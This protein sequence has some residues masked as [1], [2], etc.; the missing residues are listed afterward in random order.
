MKVKDLEQYKQIITEQ[1]T[2]EYELGSNDEP[3][4]S[5]LVGEGTPLSYYIGNISN[6]AEHSNT[7]LFYELLQNASDAQADTCYITFNDDYFLVINN[8]KPFIADGR[9]D[10]PGRLRSFLTK[11]KGVKSESSEAIGEHGQGSKL[12]Y[13]LLLP[14]HAEGVDFLK[15][16]DRLNIH[17][18]QKLDGLILFSWNHLPRLLELMDWEDDNLSSGDCLAEDIPL[19]TK[20]ILTYYPGR[21]GER[22]V[23]NGEERTLFSKEEAKAFTSFIKKSMS[24]PKVNA[25]SFDRGAAIFVKLG[26]GRASKLQQAI[27]QDLSAG[28]STSLVLLPHV[29]R[30]QINDLLV[31]QNTS[32]AKEELILDVTTETTGKQ[33]TAW[34]YYPKSPELVN[35]DLANFFKYFPI[36]KEAYGL[37]FIINSK[38]FEITTS[39][40]NFNFDDEGNQNILARI[41]EQLVSLIDDFGNQGNTEGLI[42]VISAVL[43]T[44]LD[45]MERNR[46]SGPFI[47]EIFFT[48]LLTA[49]RRN[50]P[51]NSGTKST[52]DDT[53]KVVLKKSN[54]PISSTDLNDSF[55]WI[56]DSLTDYADQLEEHL[57]IPSWGVADLHAHFINESSWKKWV[58]DL[59]AEDYQELLTELSSLSTGQLKQIPFLLFSNNEVFSLADL[60]AQENTVLLDERTRPLQQILEQHDILCGGSEVLSNDDLINKVRD[61]SPSNEQLLEQFVKLIDYSS[62]SRDEKWL[63]FRTLR[64]QWKLSK[65]DLRSKIEIFQ[66]NQGELRPLAYLLDKHRQK[67]SSG[68]LRPFQIHPVEVYHDEFNPYFLQK[69]EIW[70]VIRRHWREVSAT[71]SPDNYAQAIKELE[72][73]YENSKGS[74]L[75]DDHAW[76]MTNDM[77]LAPSSEVFFNRKIAELDAEAY[78]R[79]NKVVSRATNSKTIHALH[80]SSI[81]TQT[82]APIPSLG[83]GEFADRFEEDKIT[84]DQ[85]DLQVLLRSKELDE[86]FFSKLKIKAGPN[87]TYQL[88][89]ED[90][91]KQFFTDDPLVKSFLETQDKYYELPS[92]LS[93][94]FNDD[95][96]LIGDFGDKTEAFALQLIGDF[97]SNSA[98]IDLVQRC[99]QATK[100]RYLQGV[101]TLELSAG[102]E[103]QS[104]RGTYKGKLITL[105]VDLQQEAIIRKI[106]QIDG[107]PFSDFTHEEMITVTYGEQEAS[108]SF[109]LSSLIP[110]YQGLSD[111]WQAVK[112]KL[113]GVKTGNLFVLDRLPLSTIA[114]EIIDSAPL[115][116]PVQV[117]FF[118]AFQQSHSYDSKLHHSSAD[119]DWEGLEKERVLNK[120]Y[121]NR[122][123]GFGN[124]LPEQLLQP[125]TYIYAPNKNELLLPNEQLPDWVISWLGN[126]TKRLSY[127]QENGLHGSNDPVLLFRESILAREKIESEV[128]DTIASKSVWTNNTLQWCE[129]SL[130]EFYYKE[131]SYQALHQLIIRS[132][133]ENESL[134]YYLLAFDF[135]DANFEATQMRLIPKS[136]K[137]YYITEYL[138][139]ELSVWQRIPQQL[140]DHNFVDASYYKIN[141]DFRELLND[142]GWK[143]ASLQKKFSPLDESETQEWQARQYLEWKNFYNAKYRILITPQEI[144]FF[145]YFSVHD[146]NVEQEVGTFSKGEAVSHRTEDGDIDLILYYPGAGQASILESITAQKDV[147]FAGDYQALIK[148]LGLFSAELEE[149]EQAIL[150]LTKEKGLTSEDLLGINKDSLM[151]IRQLKLSP[152]ELIKRLESEEAGYELGRELNDEELNTLRVLIK[153]ADGDLLTA[154]ARNLDKIKQLLESDDEGSKP[155]LLIGLIG[156]ILV[157][158]WLKLEYGRENVQY[159]AL[160][161]EGD[162]WHPSYETHDLQ[163]NLNQQTYLL[164][165]KTTI[166]PIR[167]LDRTVAFFIKK[168]QYEYIANHPEQQYYIYR[169]SLQELGL[170]EFYRSLKFI[171]DQGRVDIINKFYPIIVKKI[172]SYLASPANRSDLKKLRMVFRVTIPEQTKGLF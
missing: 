6:F 107:K 131:S 99:S 78:S 133:Q 87:N 165:V 47:K 5:R 86:R 7:Q 14:A 10:Q 144:P 11:N 64:D 151:L 106:A 100:Q 69:E 102:N 48:N 90:K 119:L 135:K 104:Y 4:F 77:S 49:L 82:F 43:E 117:A 98:F 44:E 137:G 101:S 116:H 152:E 72:A 124:I 52:E 96:A 2:S 21:I 140:E 60:A 146:E 170:Y 46:Q 141:H 154:I 41:G 29:K 1:V 71:M 17:L 53:Y 109:Q 113:Q 16:A 67:A 38:E 93:E 145:Y 63:L 68:I 114:Q 81:G 123:T 169:I 121:K 30:I 129:D 91:G 24:H 34:F 127:L 73:L 155:S 9:T 136:E 36:T 143:K 103:I 28:L 158:E 27:A 149:G 51:T 74:P 37:K 83:L 126:N 13:D 61:H 85:V 79:L 45:Q 65:E 110:K 120:L 108:A 125:A 80:Y 115:T 54:L 25:S 159:T 171:K 33:K 162:R 35:P 163:L 153:K 40:Q 8:G 139:N 3:L 84:V 42:Q 57:N 134:P 105:A 130:G 26:N 138:P 160:K 58:N 161:K 112:D 19:L 70:K 172:H 122:I 157:H 56:D 167:D 23:V 128:I 118:V 32:F 12:L 15:K 150:D 39:R 168:K 166:K 31:E 75:S 147:L 156:E 89:T 111:I 62:L 142:S 92:S 55:F 50:L 20:T 164:D 94:L 59:A 66:N 88:K 18:K 132:S 148:L 22:R 95:P 76:L 97:G